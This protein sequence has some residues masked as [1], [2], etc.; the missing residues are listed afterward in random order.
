MPVTINQT[1]TDNSSDV[2]SITFSHTT[3]AG[4]NRHLF[5]FIGGGRG[6]ANVTAVTWGGDAL[7]EIGRGAEP[8]RN[9]VE[10]WHLVAEPTVKTADIVVTLDIAEDDVQTGAVSFNN[11]DQT[12]S[13][14][15]FTGAGGSGA[16]PSVTIT[17]TTADLVFGVV[18]AAVTAMAAGAGQTARWDLDGANGRGNGMGSDEVGAT[19]TT[20]SYTIIAARNGIAALSIHFSAAA[21][22]VEHKPLFVS[23]K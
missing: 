2:S 5:V 14:S 4:T 7:V 16:N 21:P 9:W 10:I 18:N 15:G 11:V 3:N 19:S 20:H 6:D 23:S 22:A 17:S 13:N 1:T 8:D 12:T